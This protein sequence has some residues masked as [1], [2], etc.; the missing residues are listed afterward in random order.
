MIDIA[1]EVIV[2]ADSSKF[3]KS[4]LAFITHFHKID[5][6]ITDVHIEKETVIMLERNNVE[7]VIAE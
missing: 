4:G 7:V 1:E 3:K 5:K 2:V 6:I